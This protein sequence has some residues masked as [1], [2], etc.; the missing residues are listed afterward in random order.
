MFHFLN[1][2]LVSDKEEVEKSLSILIYIFFITGPGYIIRNST[3]KG[4]VTQIES[5]PLRLRP[6]ENDI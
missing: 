5:L 4:T 2:G 3:H 6:Y 1:Q